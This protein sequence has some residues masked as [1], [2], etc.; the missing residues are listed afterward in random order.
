MKPN[1]Q[2]GSLLVYNIILIFIFSLVMLGALSYATIELRLLRSTVNGE[3]AFQIAEAGA[4]YYEWHLANFPTDY[5]DGNA[6]TT[7]GPYI[8]TYTDT[9]QQTV[10]GKF[11]LVITPPSL[12][13][14]VVTVQSTGTTLSD[15]NQARVVT[16]RYGIPSLAQYAFLTN[17]D[18]WIGSSETV[19]GEFLTDGRVA[20]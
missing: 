3:V 13:S 20:F 10:I 16:V 12:G 15:P 18:A 11:S 19:N 14:T 1:L 7:P 2:T 6:S 4:N 9:D 17:S 5:W 8:H